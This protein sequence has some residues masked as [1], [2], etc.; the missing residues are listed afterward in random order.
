MTTSTARNIIKI[1]PANPFTHGTGFK[2][3]SVGQQ[4]FGSIIQP[5]IQLDHYFM[6]QPIKQPLF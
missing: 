4:Q 2:A 1:V 5:F 3:F 6:T